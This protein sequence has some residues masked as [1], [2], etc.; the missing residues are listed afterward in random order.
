MARPVVSKNRS[1]FTRYSPS[2]DID[3]G[4]FFFFCLTHFSRRPNDFDSKS[5]PVIKETKRSKAGDNPAPLSTLTVRL[6]F[7]F[8]QLKISVSCAAAQFVTN[9][10][11]QFR[12]RRRRR[13]PFR[14]AP[15][16]QSAF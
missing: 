13:E 4:T 2:V 16:G 15:R 9:E 10:L 1:S 8:V 14:S 7:F 11:L 12:R 3:Y 6:V 5:H